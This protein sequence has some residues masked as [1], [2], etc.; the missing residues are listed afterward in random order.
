MV[1]CSSVEQIKSQPSLLHFTELYILCLCV[2]REPLKLRSEQNVIKFS[3]DLDLLEFWEPDVFN[4]STLLLSEERDALYVGAREAI[5]ELDKRDVTIRNQ[6]V[7][8]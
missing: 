1:N 3:S 2:S 8:E 5:F 7:K 4:Y 6:K